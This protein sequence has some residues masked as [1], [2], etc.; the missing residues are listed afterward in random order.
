MHE[1]AAI[2]T[3]AS[4]GIGLALAHMLGQEGYGLTVNS[5]RPEKIEAAGEELRAAGYEVE[6][7]PGSV[8]DEA[9]VQEVVRRHRERYGR[10]DVLVNNAGVGAGQP[11]AEMTTKML[12]LQL[13]ANLRHIPLFYRESLDLLKAAAAEHK[14]A[15]VINTSSI[16]G[17]R[18]EAWLSVYSAT[19]HG[20][21]GFTEA[22]NKELGPIGIKSTALCP[23]FVDTPMTD[24]V[25]GAVPIDKMIMT[26]DVAEMVRP[27]L[28]LSPGC[29]IPEILFEQTGFE[30]GQTL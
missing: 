15:V 19:K 8:A 28:K 10:L 27:L 29:T 11:I 13:G 30:I 23:A 14:N 16:S 21:V 25:K 3:G 26:S 5:R 12:D 1:R 17:K 20:V 22:M 18:G 4:S 9:V 24:F 2:V 7:V 6:V